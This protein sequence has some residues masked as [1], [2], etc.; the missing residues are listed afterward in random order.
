MY[1]TGSD[2]IVLAASDST[3]KTI[4]EYRYDARFR[5][6]FRWETYVFMNHF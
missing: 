4:W 5:S 2:E 3:G 6:S 1:R